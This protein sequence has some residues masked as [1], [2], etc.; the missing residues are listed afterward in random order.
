MGARQT[1]KTYILKEFG[2]REYQN[3][4]YCNFEEDPRL[5]DFFKDSLA[6]SNLLE[7][8]SIYKKQSIRPELDLLFFD[9][10]QAS[11]NALNSLKYFCEEA[12]EYHVAAAGSL[13]GVKI[14]APRSFP[15]GKVDMLSLY[16]MTFPE[17]LDAVGESRYRDWL[18]NIQSL[19]P[20]P[21][22]F[23]AA[24]IKLLKTYYFVGGM[25][26]AV[27]G[28]AETRSVEKV[29]LVQE[30]ILK[31]YVFD[32]AKHA[33]AA[34][35]PKLSIIWDSL[36]AHLARENKKFIFSAL[37][38]GARAREYESALRW[39]QDAGIIHLAHAVSTV[40]LPLAGFADR[41]AFKAYALD[42]G[43][44]GAMAR[45]A[46]EILMHGDDL[47]ATYQGA[48]TE[49]YVAQQLAAREVPGLYY[50]K[51][52]GRKAEVDFLLEDGTSVFPLEVKAGV[53][54]KSKSLQSYGHRFNP[55]LLLRTTLLNFKK[56]DHLL[57]VPLYAA[58][59]ISRYLRL[60]R[61]G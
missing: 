44:L 50:W 45:L 39:L 61:E 17:F 37:A 48:F 52:E 2:R 13:L 10:I 49:N 55:A 6:P 57:N 42:V 40:Q 35:I 53:N 58:G 14:S 25:P 15:V 36:P 26:E 3:L 43:L 27:A 59:N 16:P 56:E 30:A 23:H 38:A 34:D 11:N 41:E 4:I 33:D 31:A 21:A 46:P 20:V 32:F 29:R 47:F 24:L 51:S 5:A 22:P 19:E 28:F 8:L 1:G 18:E 7:S 12:P 60:A 54:P 9:E